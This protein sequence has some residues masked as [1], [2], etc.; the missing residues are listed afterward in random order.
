MALMN[1]SRSMALIAV[2]GA[3]LLGAGQAH[4]ATTHW[5]NDDAASLNPPGTSCGDAGYTTIQAAVNA[6][7]VGDLVNVCPGTYTENITIGTA[8]LKVASTAGAVVTVVRALQANVDTFRIQALRVTIDG[9]TIVQ[10]G[11][12]AKHDIGVNV[13]TEGS[14]LATITN[15]VIRGGRIGVNLGCASARSTVAHNRVSDSYEAGINIDTCEG[16]EYGSDGN[17][18]HDNIVCGGTYPY[19]IAAGGKSDYNQI[20][21]NVGRWMAVYGTG[22]NVHHN[23]AQFFLIVAGN[24]D[25]QNVVDPTVCTSCSR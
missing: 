13:Y 8:S 19:S 6:A 15:N 3:S 17:S 22:N 1:P 24:T 18:V 2:L 5:V 11:Q 10:A 14:T 7:A 16:S 9:F 21:H 4:A 12:Q 23:T 25:F 20:E